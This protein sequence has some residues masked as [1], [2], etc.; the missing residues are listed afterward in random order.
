MRQLVIASL[1]VGALSPL[2]LSAQ[3]KGDPDKTVKDGGVLAKGWTGR[4]DNPE[5]QD[6]NGAKF[7]SM[8]DG[9]HVTAGPPALYWKPGEKATG[10][11]TVKASFTQTKAPAHPEAYGLFIGG[12]KLDSPDQNYLYCVVFGTGMFSV[13]HRLGSEV[14]SLVDRKESPA[15]K[16]ADDSG[17]ATNE[18]SWVV[19]KDKV[20][21]NANGTELASFPRADVIGSGKLETLDGIYG[22]RV[23]HNLDVHISGFG[24]S[25]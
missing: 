2:A 21:C 19:S 3:Q 15:I 4:T 8:G 25:K 6:I 7:V 1:L 10:N 5:K 13:K 16:K 18:L 23:N 12:T 24:L 14:H 11:Y 17:K 9:L 20:S 22:I